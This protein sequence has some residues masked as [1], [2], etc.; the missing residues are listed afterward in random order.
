M[1]YVHPYFHILWFQ[2]YSCPIKEEIGNSQGVGGQ[3]KNKITRFLWKKIGNAKGV[4]ESFFPNSPPWWGIDIFLE[5][6][7]Y[8]CYYLVFSIITTKK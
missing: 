3:K 8:Y 1:N 7:N 5:P 2:K 4:R 6:H